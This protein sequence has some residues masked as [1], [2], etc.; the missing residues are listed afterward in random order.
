M[1]TLASVT[2]THGNLFTGLRVV[3]LGKP[4]LAVYPMVL[5]R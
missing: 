4:I 1:Y 3:S 5:E 2:D